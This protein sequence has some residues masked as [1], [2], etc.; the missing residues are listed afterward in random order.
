MIAAH[1]A[2][3]KRQRRARR[4]ARHHVVALA[5]AVTL[6]A[7]GEDLI[8]FV[9]N[10]FAV[11]VLPP[12]GGGN[13][14]I[15]QGGTLAIDVEFAMGVNV[16]GTEIEIR[17]DDA[18][19]PTGVMLGILD[20]FLKD[21]Q[22]LSA[23]QRDTVTYN[24]VASP[25]APPGTYQVMV[26]G[27][28]EI[29]AE[30]SNTSLPDTETATFALIVVASGGDPNGC[31]DFT[32]TSEATPYDVPLGSPLQRATIDIERQSGFTGSIRFTLEGPTDGVLNEWGFLPD[33]SAEPY[34]AFDFFVEPSATPGTYDFVIRGEAVGDPASQCTLEFRINVVGG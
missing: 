29:T 28:A 8:G 33:P 20:I 5:A 7:C 26:E 24:L 23:E 9:P 25:T 3:H 10:L 2:A 1:P 18:S 4:P 32:L 12:A 11:T 6:G 15:E 30:G 16:S 22:P 34:V 19:L 31:T 14:T 21:I 17:F 13:H 27:R